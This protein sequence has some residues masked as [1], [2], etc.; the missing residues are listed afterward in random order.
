MNIKTDCVGII[1]GTVHPEHILHLLSLT[2]FLAV[3]NPSCPYFQ[4][5]FH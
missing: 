2:A 4:D 3:V 5:H 1:S